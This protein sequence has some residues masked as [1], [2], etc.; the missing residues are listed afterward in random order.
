VKCTYRL[1]VHHE[2]YSPFLGML[3]L[4]LNTW[5]IDRYWKQMSSLQ[6]RSLWHLTTHWADYVSHFWQRNSCS[7]C[8]ETWHYHTSKQCTTCLQSTH[9][10]SPSGCLLWGTKSNISLFIKKFQATHNSLLKNSLIV[11]DTV[12]V[13]YLTPLQRLFP[14]ELPK[15]SPVC[16][17]VADSVLLGYSTASLGTHF[18]SS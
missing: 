13:S 16:S 7:S 3:V 8:W 15:K 4:K 10:S 5:W 14:E 11:Q 12:Q 9:I 2:V 17:I 6:I 18:S 1:S